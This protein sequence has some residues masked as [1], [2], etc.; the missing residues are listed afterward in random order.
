[1]LMIEEMLKAITNEQKNP[2]SNTTS[3]SSS[4]AKNPT[5]KNENRPKLILN[6]HDFSG[7]LLYLFINQFFFTSCAVYLFVF[8]L[9]DD[10]E[11]T[12]LS[13]Y[14]NISCIS[15]FG[16]Q[17]LNILHS[18]HLWISLIHSTIA[19]F[20]IPIEVSPS[21]PPSQSS[22]AAAAT[23]TL[24]AVDENGEQQQQEEPTSESPKNDENST[25]TQNNSGGRES[26]TFELLQPQI[27]LVGT[28]RNSIHAEPIT[29]NQIVKEI[30]DKIRSSFADKSYSGHL[31]EKHIALDCKEMSFDE[32]ELIENLRHL[33]ETL[34]FDEKKAGFS[35]PLCWIQLEQILEKFK[36]R[37]IYFVDVYQLHE[38][39]SS[40]IDMFQ[41]YENLNSALYFYHNQGKIF[42]LDCINN[43]NAFASANDRH[44]SYELGIIILDPNWFIRCIYDLCSYLCSMKN[45]GAGDDDDD[46]LFLGI[47]SENAINNAWSN[48]I[49]QKFI[50]LGCLENLDLICEIN[51]YLPM[52]DV[53]DISATATVPKLYFFPWI[54]K[55]LINNND[56][57]A[58]EFVNSTDE[59]GDSGGGGQ[60]TDN[61]TNDSRSESPCDESTTTATTIN[62]NSMING[63]PSPDPNDECLGGNAN[64]T[65]GGSTFQF[66]IEFNILP[67]SLFT[68]L[69][70][71]LS[72]WSW[73]QGWGRKPEMFNSKG[74]IAVE[75]DHDIIL[76]INLFQHRIYLII[77]KIFEE[78]PN[79]Q[80]ENLFIGPAANVCV[81]VQHLI[82]NEL[83]SL[84]N[85]YYRRLSFNLVI[86]CPCDV[87]CEKHSIEGCLDESCLHFLSLHEC[88]QKK[89][90]ECRFNRQVRT[91]FIH[92]FLPYTPINLNNDISYD[93]TML[94]PTTNNTNV[95]EN[96]FQVEQL[97]MREAAKL[98]NVNGKKSHHHHIVGHHNNN[99]QQSSSSSSSTTNDWMALA[100][101]LS[102]T[103]RD[104]MK[105][106][107]ELSPSLALLNDWYESNGRT[108]YCIDVLVSCLRMLRR[109][110]IAS[111]IEYE[112]E[113]ESSS[114][115]IF[116][117]YQH[118]S[119]KQVLGK[120]VS[121]SMCNRE[122]AL[123]DVLHKP[124][125]PLIIEFTPW[126]PPGAMA[127]IMSS[128]VYVDLCGVGSHHGTGRTQ[129]TET[130]FREIGHHHN[131]HQHQS[132]I[133]RIQSS[134]SSMIL[135]R[136]NSHESQISPILM[137]SDIEHLINGG[138]G[139]GG[140]GAG[141]GNNISEQNTRRNSNIGNDNVDDHHQQSSS[142]NNSQ[143]LTR[144]ELPFTEQIITDDNIS[145][146]T[147]A[148]IANRITNCS[149]CLII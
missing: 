128:I 138:D 133:R 63:H 5:N 36:Q 139:G 31:F 110:D 77:V 57:T 34:I 126:P 42:Y 106:N 67:I 53:P 51:P 26:K 1:M 124:I 39:V 83:A 116:L 109:E 142:R 117:S 2:S 100:K 17:S 22:S 20:P 45:N 66:I 105:F 112:L 44:G 84:K 80:I 33:I 62:N 97:W 18:I 87:I 99:L 3:E 96:V 48:I 137:E 14:E 131:H 140:A 30:F 28:H 130:R 13:K 60:N 135:R 56:T 101:R 72:K 86:P 93:N 52:E 147:R 23:T 54:T 70:V 43:Q 141:G 103:E 73:N 9:S 50:L 46:N 4:T 40:Q 78:I 132:L 38:V 69:L 129:D 121:S 59:A 74:R 145:V 104:I 127:L 113:P 32:P 65:I 37:G 24:T 134:T 114:P 10:I 16:N 125:L 91:T 88:L 11:T 144:D 111:L 8:N 119:Q 35:I 123:A 6:I 108:R 55:P 61:Q 25:Q 58:S 29:R 95:W 143:Q 148:R 94:M 41:S 89:V 118:D 7:N 68:R 149:V 82:E 115:P 107:S 19:G 75:F 76:K 27:L 136:N 120:Y 71:R 98:L 92:R 85:S 79:D 12:T 102:Y 15:E 47:I 21:P 146:I 81:K 122:V 49:D 90:V 64:T